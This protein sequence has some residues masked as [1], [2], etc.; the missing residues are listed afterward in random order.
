MGT[1]DP[2]QHL[3]DIV[4]QYSSAIVAFS[5]G[6][7][8][9]LVALAAARALG[10]QNML[11]VLA[12]SPSVARDEIRIARQ[13]AL[14]AHFRLEIVRTGE[15]NDP[16]YTANNGQRCYFCKSELFS[17]L[18]RLREQKGFAVVLDGYNQDDIGDYRPGL[19]AGQEWQVV[20]P[21]KL[22][23]LGK[24]AIREVARQWGLK[25]WAKPASPCL[26]SRIPYQ[27]PVTIE[28][29]RQVEEAEAALHRLG[30]VE[31]RVRHHWPVARIEVPVNDLHEMVQRRVEVVEAVK[32][33]GYRFVS[34]D[35]VGLSSGGLNVLLNV[36]P[37]HSP[38]R[39]KPEGGQAGAR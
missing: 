27:T 26:A 4:S 35:L 37:T 33:A 2:G 9:S 39:E 20:S 10:P 7:D 31:V 12:D 5:G 14:D 28:N 21:L 25:N 17:T 3:L 18:T 32:K 34:V 13:L 38:S 1:N 22:A 29:L 36:N 30:F 19:V 16:R 15:L 6:V 11:A 8:S 24:T 23:G